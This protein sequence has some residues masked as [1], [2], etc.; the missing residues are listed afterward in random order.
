MKTV[1]C[2]CR[3][4]ISTKM[5]FAMVM[6]A[7][8]SCK[9]SKNDDPTPN[10]GNNQN[11]DKVQFVKLYE[12]NFAVKSDG[13]LWGWGG[14]A[15]Y[16]NGY[17]TPHELL[18]GGI[19]DFQNGFV[20]KDDGT[21]WQ[22]GKVNQLT[23]MASTCGPYKGRT[24]TPK[25]LNNYT[26]TQL[27]SDANWVKVG[28][29]NN[30]YIYNTVDRPV[31]TYSWWEDVDPN[32][33]WC[34]GWYRDFNYWGTFWK[35]PSTYN[36]WKYTD[37]AGTIGLRS[38]GVLYKIASESD[39]NPQEYNQTTYPNIFKEIDNN[40]SEILMTSGGLVYKKMDGTY[41]SEVNNGQ[42]PLSQISVTGDWKSIVSD[43]SGGRIIGIKTDG[44][45][46]AWGT[47][48]DG[49]LGD[50]TYNN[51]VSPLKLSEKTNWM[52]ISAGVSFYTALDAD[53]NIYGWGKNN[54]GQLG[55]GTTTDKYKPTLVIAAKSN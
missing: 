40:V 48:Q 17:T 55:D 7:F 43:Y 21:L 9:T 42:S 49:F 44:T 4:R 8:S 22:M 41:W 30:G 10:P 36:D 5:L 3:N 14:L 28:V 29:K 54:R 13:S 53:G 23:F 19:K 38:N 6:I 37:L 15:G 50:G 45:L 51:Q 33:W 35:I 24:F 18:K 2:I 34:K 20:V 26:Y 12:G 39:Y 27:S 52:E 32:V 25:T 46:W 47:N 31:F 11:T 16:A 1:Q